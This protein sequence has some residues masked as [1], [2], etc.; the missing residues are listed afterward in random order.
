MRPFGQ[1]LTALT[2]ATAGAY[3]TTKLQRLLAVRMPYRPFDYHY[4]NL[5]LRE[6]GVPHDTLTEACRAEL[7]QRITIN[8]KALALHDGKNWRRVIVPLTMHSANLVAQIIQEHTRKFDN[9]WPTQIA[10]V[11]RMHGAIDPQPR[12]RDV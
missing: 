1:I 7:M 5:A 8:S 2:V 6:L 11:L 3:V 10:Q 12:G 9:R 4:F